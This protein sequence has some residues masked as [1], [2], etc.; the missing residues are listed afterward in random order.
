MMGYILFHC[1]S[2]EPHS[3][4]T[5]QG[6][7]GHGKR[8]NIKREKSRSIGRTM[9]LD[10]VYLGT[11]LIRFAASTMCFRTCL[12]RNLGLLEILSH[13]SHLGHISLAANP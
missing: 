2:K 4:T 8:W 5:I 10:L 1:R 13:T 6:K 12:K 3:V 11:V 9:L 7:V